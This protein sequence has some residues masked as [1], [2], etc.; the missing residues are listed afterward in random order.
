MDA[1]ED[2]TQGDML[3]PETDAALLKLEGGA[4]DAGTDAVHECAAPEAADVLGTSLAFAFMHCC[5]LVPLPQL[6]AQQAAASHALEGVEAG[7]GWDFNRLVGASMVMLTSGNLNTREG[8][9]LRARMWRLIFGQSSD[10]DAAGSWAPSASVAFSLFAVDADELKRANDLP[11]RKYKLLGRLVDI[12]D[13]DEDFFEEDD[14]E[15]AEYDEDEQEASVHQVL[16]PAKQT[17][18][19]PQAF[20]AWRERAVASRMAALAAQGFLR[21]AEQSADC[22]L[23]ATAAPLCLSVPRALRLARLTP[24][25][26]QPPQTAAPLPKDASF[27]A[28]LALMASELRSAAGSQTRGP[29]AKG[30]GTL[31]E[32]LEQLTQELQERELLGAAG[33]PTLREQLQAMTEQLRT[34]QPAVRDNLLDGG[35]YDSDSN[36]SDAKP[37]AAAAGGASSFDEM[38][39]PR[40]D[41]ERVW[42]TMLVLSVLQRFSES[43]LFSE[44]SDPL[45]VTIVD[46]GYAFLDRQAQAHPALA[47]ALA[48]GSLQRKASNLT[49][50]WQAVLGN[51][52][53]EVRAAESVTSH[54]SLSHVQRTS[55]QVARAMVVRHETF[56]TFL[57]PALDG[58][59]VRAVLRVCALH[60]W[61]SDV[62]VARFLPPAQRWQMFIILVTLVLSSLLVNSACNERRFRAICVP[63]ALAC[64]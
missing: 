25:P 43:C 44:D 48:D 55:A 3:K 21:R 14:G 10:G 11:R 26:E 40:L 57:A 19:V 32:K 56:G 42:T 7:P 47:A 36:A 38:P 34:Q 20:R 2:A 51:R 15:N 49:A 45:E 30:V 9:L 5:S 23:T 27:T 54:M 52:V 33:S 41:C 18:I 50:K 6:A 29:S 12:F 62:A 37:D 16:D 28:K 39:P 22:V 63:L 61:H 1:E 4:D 53:A 17:G 24:P 60:A 8:W 58:L 59:Q 13:G 64:F 31:R 35:M 46:A